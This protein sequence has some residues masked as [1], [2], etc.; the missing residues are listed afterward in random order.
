MRNAA[1]PV[2]LALV[3]AAGCVGRD[4]DAA[5]QP[6]ARAD[7]GVVASDTP[8]SP[9]SPRSPARPEASASDTGVIVAS[10]SEL[11][12]LAAVMS[13]PVAGV[14]ASDLRDSYD[15]MRGTRLHEAIDIH[16]ERGTPVLASTDGRVLK[17]HE[18]LAGGL[19]LYAADSSD[20]FILMYGHLDRYA[21]GIV[22]GMRLRRG[23][24]IGYVGTS[25]NAPANTPHL[26]F[27]IA[28]GR[29]SSTW[30]LGTPV[31]PYPLLSRVTLRPLP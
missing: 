15:E 28:R 17:R 27:A 19:M 26:H 20:R 8:S 21:P 22:E 12:A 9:R 16:A 3:L 29:P 24:L 18:S 23:Q 13:I 5:R 2:I 11:D 14:S 6:D 25:G 31:N 7:G 30:W 1:L 10:A 4:D